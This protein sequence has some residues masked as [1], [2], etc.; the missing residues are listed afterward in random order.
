MSPKTLATV[1][2][3]CLNPQA[4]E[5][6]IQSGISVATEGTSTP[7]SVSSSLHTEATSHHQSPMVSP[8]QEI[9]DPFKKVL[10]V[11]D[12]LVNLKVRDPSVSR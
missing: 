8:Q 6:D 3:S 9:R 1:F 2:E 7:K 12:N 4:I 5:Q 10:L 11:E